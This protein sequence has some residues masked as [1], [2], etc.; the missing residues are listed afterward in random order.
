VFCIIDTLFFPAFYN[1]TDAKTEKQ[2]YLAT[3]SPVVRAYNRNGLAAFLLANLL[4]GLVNMT[5]NTLEASPTMTLVI[6]I[7]YSLT[8]TVV[9]VLLDIYDIS[10]KL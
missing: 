3:T 4:T 7:G 2:A 9:T 1:A 10:I 8:V 6:L 5:V